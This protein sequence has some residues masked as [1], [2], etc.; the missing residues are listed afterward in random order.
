MREDVRLIPISDSQSIGSPGV[1][2]TYIAHCVLRLTS[3]GPPSEHV[4]AD[5]RREALTSSEF[6]NKMVLNTEGVIIHRQVVSS[7]KEGEPW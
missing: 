3:C 1:R 4:P 6:L 2:H 7:L 5:S